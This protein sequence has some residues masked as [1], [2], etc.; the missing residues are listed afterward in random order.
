M[1]IESFEQLRLLD[2]YYLIRRLDY[3]ISLNRGDDYILR[4]D[5]Y[6][7]RDGKVVPAGVK[8]SGWPMEQDPRLFAQCFDTAIKV[9]WREILELP[10]DG[11]VMYRGKAYRFNFNTYQW[12]VV[13][14]VLPEPGTYQTLPPAPFGTDPFQPQC[15]W[16]T[17]D[18]QTQMPGDFRYPEPSRSG[19]AI[20]LF[21]KRVWGWVRGRMVVWW[22]FGR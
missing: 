3:W 15:E 19:D 13:Q 12:D 11:F 14:A 8:A 7:C 5:A 17:I 22:R 21:A 9:W 2:K 6:I 20:W 4:T 18:E 16:G 1:S 10:P